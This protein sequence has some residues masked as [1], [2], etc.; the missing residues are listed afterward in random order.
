MGGFLGIG[1]SSAKT[2]RANQLSGINASWNLYNRGLPMADKAQATG[3]PAVAGGITGLDQAKQYWSKIMS[4]NRPAVMEAAAPALTNINQ[5]ADAARAEQAQMGT[6]RGGGTSAAN[7][8]AETNRMTQANQLIAGLQPQAAAG[9]QAA[10][11]AEAQAGE[12][13]MRDA[14]SAM[15]LSQ[16]VADEIINSSITS[17]PISISANNSVAQQWSNVLSWLGMGGMGG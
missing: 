17:R 9:V 5:Q 11:T 6:A 15:G 7:Q 3:F 10:S 8:Q 14:L 12:A 2:D 1:H 4:G 16:N 13:Q